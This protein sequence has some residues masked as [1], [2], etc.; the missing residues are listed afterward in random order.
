MSPSQLPRL[1]SCLIMGS[2]VEEGL[3]EEMVGVDAVMIATAVVVLVVVVEMVV[4]VAAEAEAE[5]V[6]GAITTMLPM[7]P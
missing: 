7:T 1:L 6:K 5:A 4:V 3:V 2:Q